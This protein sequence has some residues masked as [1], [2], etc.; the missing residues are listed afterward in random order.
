MRTNFV[1]KLH[2][3]FFSLNFSLHSTFCIDVSDDIFQLT[4]KDVLKTEL[5]VLNVS[6]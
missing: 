6:F 5:H 2:R 4:S 3:R 1:K